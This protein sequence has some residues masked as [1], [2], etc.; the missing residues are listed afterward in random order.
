VDF[1]ALATALKVRADGDNAAG[2][3]GT[4]ASGRLI[5]GFFTEAAPAAT[6]MPHI[7]LSN[8][9]ELPSPTFTGNV[10]T[11]YVRMSIYVPRSSA[12]ISAPL[13]RLWAIVARVYGDFPTNSPPS[14]GF[15]RWK[16]TL[17]GSTWTA[18]TMI[19]EPMI[20]TTDQDF[21][22]KATQFR[23]VLSK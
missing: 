16:P 3:I 11:F 14:Y 4:G 5:T 12:G 21:Y 17:S 18:D 2:G 15:E 23:L 6:V 8:Y 7:I 10:W 1:S 20:D 19:S 22:S 9:G 13:S